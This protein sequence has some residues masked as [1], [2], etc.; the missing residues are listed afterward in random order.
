MLSFFKSKPA[1]PEIDF[2]KL[3]TDIHSHVIP[4]IDDGAQNLAQSVDLVRNLSELGFGKIITTPH[5]MVDYFR[6]TQETIYT[7]L[8]LLKE[9]L[10]IQKLDIAIEAAAEYYFD[11]DFENK[12]ERVISL[13]SAQIIFYSKYLLAPIRLTCLKQLKKS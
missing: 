10:Q 3:G 5:I 9:E 4:G 11:E 7:G 2:S 13:H 1:I 8:D 6:N 12:I